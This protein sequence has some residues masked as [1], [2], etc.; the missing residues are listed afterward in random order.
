[1]DDQQPAHGDGGSAPTAAAGPAA[2]P[3]ADPRG[4][5]IAGSLLAGLGLSLAVAFLM[6]EVQEMSPNGYAMNIDGDVVAVILV[7]GPVFGLGLALALLALMPPGRSQSPGASSA[8]PV[9]DITPG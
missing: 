5:L 3:Q 1:M 7:A 6:H 4:L 8:P 2:V 9:S